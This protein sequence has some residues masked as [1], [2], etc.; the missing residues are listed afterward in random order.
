[1][2]PGNVAS[3]VAVPS[4]FTPPDDQVSSPLIDFERG[5]LALNNPSLGLNYQNWSCF[6]AP[7][8]LDVQVQAES[9]A[10]ITIFQQ[11]A[12]ETLTFTF[13]QNMRPCVAYQIGDVVYLRW[14][15]SVPQAFVV[16][17]FANIRDPKLALDDKRITQL[18][19]NSDIIFAYISGTN[20]C[21]RQQ[22]ERFNTERVIRTGLPAS[23]G[24]KNIGMGRNL[25][26]Q[27]EI[28]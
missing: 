14:Y 8:G 28:A 22:R 9:G 5:G 1:M 6:V 25:R 13:D 17:A 20:L 2:L 10:P 24:L 3:T 21:Y 7:N 4:E 11:A 18:A 26:L 12:I 19:L 23:L 15:D 27:F 16:T